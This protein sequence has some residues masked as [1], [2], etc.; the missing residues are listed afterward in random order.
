MYYYAMDGI[1]SIQLEPHLV[2]WKK[3]RKN[4]FVAINVSTKTMIYL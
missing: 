4:M 1:L 2:N 3:E